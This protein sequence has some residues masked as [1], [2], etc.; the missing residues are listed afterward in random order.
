MKASHSRLP[1]PCSCK[2][3]RQRPTGA[4]RAGCVRGPG[5]GSFHR[6]RVQYL[7]C[8]PA[9]TQVGAVAPV[10]KGA[11]TLVPLEGN[12]FPS[13]P[14]LVK[15]SP[16]AQSTPTNG[17]TRFDKPSGRPR[18]SQAVTATTAGCRV[19]AVLP[20]VPWFPRGGGDNHPSC[21]GIVERLCQSALSFRRCN[22]REGR[23]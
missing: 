7:R 2:N 23:A 4:G 16:G 8:L 13:A 17:T 22:L 21:R 5:T 6:S 11:A 14:R 9:E 20:T 1:W 19:M 18:L 3:R 10:T 12:P 15:P